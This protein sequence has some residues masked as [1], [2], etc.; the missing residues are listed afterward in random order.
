MPE[1]PNMVSLMSD[2]M[3]AKV[4][5]ILVSGPRN[6]SKSWTISEC[7]LS[8]CELYPGIQIANIRKYNEDLGG[9]LNQWDNYI[10]EYGLD[11]KR[12]P[13]TFHERTKAEPRK[14][15]RF[16]NG[17]RIFFLG[18]DKPNKA[19]GSAL[20]FAY[21]NEVQ[22]EDNPEH[23]QAILGAMEGGRAGNWPGGKHLA[24]ADMNP[25][26]KQFWAYL[27][28]NPE[29]ENEVPAMK[30]YRISHIDHPQFYVWSLQQWTNKG[31]NT[32]DGLKRAYGPPE[33][34]DYR[35]NVLG[36]FCNTEGAVYPEFVPKKHRRKV[37][38]EE[39]RYA[40]EW[41]WAVDFGGDAPM[42]A[43]LIAKRSGLPYVI[44]KEIYS[45]KCD[46]RPMIVEDLIRQMREI[47]GFYGISS[48]DITKCVTDHL[49]ENHEQLS[50]AGY[51]V[52]L[53]KKDIRSGIQV[54]KKLLRGDQIILNEDSLWEVDHS[55]GSA[56]KCFFDEI[57]KYAY[58]RE[59]ERK[60][61]DSDEKPKKGEDHAMDWFRYWAKEEMQEPLY[62]LN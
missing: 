8:L 34:F 42:A 19:L 36:E 27:R 32:T 44:F 18:M 38:W 31:K 24:I 20:D 40:D 21:Y 51:P 60:H 47:E 11:D 14:H 7:E 15:I 4:P 6:C 28:A 54:V 2:I 43:G 12:N 26:H 23:W 9:L 55:L 3:N 58:R 22:L 25:T 61:D 39:V 49:T 59:H 46:G 10:L 57:L 53:G 37:E 30:H 62:Y 16:D 35:R 1:S 50:R 29:D 48:Y 56:A 17:S 5:E 41:H 33:S 52:I 45:S 13:F